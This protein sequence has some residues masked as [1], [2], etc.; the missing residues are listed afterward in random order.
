MKDDVALVAD[1]LEQGTK[2]FGPIV[3]RYQDAVFGVAL[4]RLRNFH[5]AEDIALKRDCTMRVSVLKR[6]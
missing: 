3:E 2:A 1:V 6:I 4:A 5:D